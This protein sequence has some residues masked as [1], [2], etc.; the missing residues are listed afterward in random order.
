MHV[1]FEDDGQ[2]KAATVLADQETSLQVEAA[3]GKRSKIKASSVLLRFA[4]PSPAEALAEGAAP[5]AG[6]RPDVPLGGVRRRRVRL[7]RA[8][9]RVLRCGHDCAAAGARSRCCCT[10]RRCTSTRRA[11]AATARRRRMRSTQRSRRSS[12]RSSEA[13]QV[14]AWVGGARSA[15]AA[16]RAAREAAD[17]ALQ[18]RQECAGMEGA[19]RRLRR[20]ANRSGRAAGRVRG[21]R[22]DARLSLRPFRRRGVSARPRLSRVGRVAGAARPAARATCARSR[23]TT[24]TTTEIDDAFSV[25][26]LPNGHLEVGIHIAAPGACDCARLA[27]RRNRA[28]RACRRSTC[29]DA[30]SRCCPSPR[31]TR[32]R[33]RPARRGPRCRSTS[34]SRPTAM[35]CATRHASTVCPSP[36]TCAW[37][38]SARHSPAICRRPP[39]RRGRPSCACCGSS[40]SSLSHARGKSDIQRIDYSFDVDWDAPGVPEPRPRDDRAARRAARR[41]TSWSPS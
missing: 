17:A 34:K 5:C 35:S 23:S 12:A 26:E 9:A 8:R 20:S 24:H 16:R 1:L 41:S 14:E 6:P 25:R 10:A 15:R 2:L 38:R 37:T 28:R 11:R 18:A 36:R 7:R 39:T 40:R 13:V 31:S 19:E 3:S 21:D 4:A 32:S 27:A 33:W 22:L 29:R 30:R